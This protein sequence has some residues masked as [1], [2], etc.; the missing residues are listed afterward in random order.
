MYTEVKVGHIR[1]LGPTDEESLILEH[2]CIMYIHIKD[3]VVLENQY[4]LFL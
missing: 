2:D 1:P 3:H 4:V